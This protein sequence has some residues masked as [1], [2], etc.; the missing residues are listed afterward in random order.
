MS[1]A[2]FDL[3]IGVGVLVVAIV[4]ISIFLIFLHATDQWGK[5]RIDGKELTRDSC[6][7]QCRNYGYTESSCRVDP[8]RFCFRDVTNP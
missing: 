3:K 2:S 4:L 8:W 6:E 5:Q 1:E 7:L